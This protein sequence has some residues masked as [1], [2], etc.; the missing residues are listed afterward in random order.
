[1]FVKKLVLS[2]V[3]L[4]GMGSLGGMPMNLLRH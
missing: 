1:M 3:L 2:L 4:L